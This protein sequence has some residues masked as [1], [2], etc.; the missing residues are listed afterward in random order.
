MKYVNYEYVQEVGIQVYIV[1]YYKK[2][3]NYSSSYSLDIQ[4]VNGLVGIKYLCQINDNSFS[5]PR[6]S[7][8]VYICIVLH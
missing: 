8:S 2:I 5:H 1:T 4:Y 3:G 6:D 7:C